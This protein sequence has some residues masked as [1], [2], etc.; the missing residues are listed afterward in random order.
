MLGQDSDR[1]LAVCPHGAEASSGAKI[2]NCPGNRGH[3]PGG[4]SG[5]E[6]IG[7]CRR[8]KRCG[9]DPWVGKIPWR[10]AWQCTPVFLPRESPE[11]RSL[12][13]YSPWV[14]K[15]WTRFSILAGFERVLFFAL[16]GKISC[17]HERASLVAQRL[18]CLPA[19][20]ET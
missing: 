3:F 8:H 6:P 1:S 14:P 9:F 16:F 17:I 18:K 4:V 10:R 11:Q 19:M 12:V 5:K 7:Q 15:S 20:W 13:G 2:A